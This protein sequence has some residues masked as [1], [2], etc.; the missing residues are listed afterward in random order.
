MRQSGGRVAG[1][2][3]VRAVSAFTGRR[4]FSVW[5]GCAALLGFFGIE[6]VL[7]AK[8]D[9]VWAWIEGYVNTKIR[10]D[11]D[12][13]FRAWA[14]DDGNLFIVFLPPLLILDN[15]FSLP[16]GHY[17]KGVE[18]AFKISIPDDFRVP[19]GW[20]ILSDKD[21]RRVRFS[22]QPHAMAQYPIYHPH[23]SSISGN[24]C[25]TMGSWGEQAYTLSAW[26]MAFWEGFVIDPDGCDQTGSMYND[27]AKKLWKEDRNKYWD[28]VWEK[29]RAHNY[30]RST[31]DGGYPWVEDPRSS[32]S[33]AEFRS[34]LKVPGY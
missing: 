21:E 14:T 24:A 23:M 12:P 34:Y 15:Y 1:R 9:M 25:F 4:L 28:K 32:S 26:I 5:L 6:P 18:L 31:D 7:G 33:I 30:G 3:A 27:E 20:S 17:Y 2:S 29:S 16:P 22:G 8:R 19:E 11:E 10:E 13:G